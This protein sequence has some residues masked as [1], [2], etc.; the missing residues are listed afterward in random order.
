[1][2]G[3]GCCDLAGRCIIGQDG[4]QL[5]KEAPFSLKVTSWLKSGSVK[6]GPILWDGVYERHATSQFFPSGRVIRWLTELL[7]CVVRDVST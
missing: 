6:S 1:M 5:C 3:C 4:G 7:Y 2:T